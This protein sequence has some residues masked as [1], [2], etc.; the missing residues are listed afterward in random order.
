MNLPSTALFSNREASTRAPL[1]LATT[2]G[3]GDGEVATASVT[4]LGE[5]IFSEG[6]VYFISVAFVLGNAELLQ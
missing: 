4:H 3:A 5:L 2:I 6:L 1:V